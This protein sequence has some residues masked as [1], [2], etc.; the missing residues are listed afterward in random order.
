MN[1]SKQNK[2]PRESSHGRK[3]KNKQ[4]KNKTETETM[5]TEHEKF[6]PNGSNMRSNVEHQLGKMKEK[7]NGDQDVSFSTQF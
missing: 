4:E 2:S 6:N 1:D 5:T 7:F 3:E